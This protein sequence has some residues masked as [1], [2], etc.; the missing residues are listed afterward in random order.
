MSFPIHSRK[1]PRLSA[2]GQ[3]PQE[4]PCQ[5]RRVIV[6]WVVPTA[7][8]TAAQLVEV[9]GLLDRAFAG[10]F[11][12][13]DW[14]H[15]MGGLHILVTEDKDRI[16]GHAAV[17]RRQ[18]L[19]DDRPIRTGYVEAVAVDP[20]RRGRGH[21]AKAMV[22]I[23]RIIRAAYE[24]GALS[25]SRGVQGFYRS[26]GWVA[27]QGQTAVLSR[28]GITRTPDDDGSVF[29]LPVPATGELSVTGVLA[30]EWRDGDV[31]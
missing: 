10:R 11:D 25:A 7:Y 18:L 5:N 24:L 23:E 2:P 8:L 21:A 19:Y 29:V 26:R 13:A 30:C 1:A 3:R 4:I 20:N 27:W 14:G 28:T 16:V 6:S 9:R 22:E 12:D 31:W 17:V 15:A